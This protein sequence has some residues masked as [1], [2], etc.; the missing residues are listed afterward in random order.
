M[1]RVFSL[2]EMAADPFWR[3]N[4][5]R[6][7]DPKMNRSSS[8]WTFQK[9]LEEASED[10]SP[11]TAAAAALALSTA[12]SS[13][14]PPPP[15]AADRDEEVLETKKFH[16]SDPSFAHGPA[17]P[18]EYQTLLKRRL[19][20]ACAAVALSRASDAKP[21]DSAP[22]VDGASNSSDA[23]RLASQGPGKVSGSGSGLM[24]TQDKAISGSSGISSLPPVQKNPSTQAIPATSGS[25]R[26]QSDDE[27][28]E[29]ETETT[30]HDPADT[31]RM[32]RCAISRG[33]CYQRATMQTQYFYHFQR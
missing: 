33:R 25:S 6:S 13:P 22:S 4:G 21:Q 2:E 11:P 30:E 17:D 27:E 14:P 24:W 28:L 5:P 31:K 18:T 10:P 15:A 12:S 29:A 19:D 9:F 32:R 1:D 20:L 8:E 7:E 16:A 26:D 23:L 3:A